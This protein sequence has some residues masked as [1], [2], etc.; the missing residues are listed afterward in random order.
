MNA[1]NALLDTLGLAD[2]PQI[3][4]TASPASLGPMFFTPSQAEFREVHSRG[5]DGQRIYAAEPSKAQT[6][7]TGTAPANAN[8][9]TIERNPDGSCDV[10]RL[11]ATADGWL[12]IPGTIPAPRK[13]VHW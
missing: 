2:A 3:S 1:D 9:G 4:N 5:F 13:V 8:V 7:P 6:S 11:E 12:R 10:V